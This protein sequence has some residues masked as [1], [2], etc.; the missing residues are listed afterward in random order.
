MKTIPLKKSLEATKKANSRLLEAIDTL[1]NE[2]SKDKSKK[3]VLFDAVV[4]RFE[5]LFEY[6]WKMLK[7]AS[8]YEGIE[9]PG[10]R[11]AIQEAV[12]FGWITD[13]E[14]WAEALDARNGSVHDY[15]GISEDKYLK[16]ITRFNKEIESII[17][18]L[19]KIISK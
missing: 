13:P 4:K 3:E 15:F 6:T 11:P 14:F 5:V 18:R 17:P 2:S 19:E 10:P 9:A 12:R 8:E 16:V 7:V 1:K